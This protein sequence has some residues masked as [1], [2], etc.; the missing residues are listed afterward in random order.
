MATDI[1]RFGKEP[2]FFLVCFRRMR[3][4][5][6][7]LCRCRECRAQCSVFTTVCETCGTQ[8]PVRL[9]LTWAVFAVSVCAAVLVIRCAL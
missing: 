7:Q 5:C 9:P 8:D 6:Q 3:T 2:D 4:A 1:T